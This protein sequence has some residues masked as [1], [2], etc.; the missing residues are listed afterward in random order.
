V[1]H[2]LTIHFVDKWIDIQLD[3]LKKNIKSPYRVYT[4]LGENYEEHKDKFYYC[5]SG[6]GFGGKGHAAG[7]QELRNQLR[8]EDVDKN[9]IILVLDS[10]A[11][12]IAPIDDYLENKLENYEFLAIS[13]PNHNF[14][15]TPIQP[16]E[17]FYAFRYEFFNKYDFW[18]K[19][20]PGVHANWIDWMID[21]FKDKKIEWYPL[22]RSNKVNLHPLYYAV[23]DKIIYHHWCGTRFPIISRPD[24]VMGQRKGI[25]IEKISQVNKKNS[26]KVINQIKNQSEQFLAYLMGEYDGEL[27]NDEN[28]NIN[29]INGKRLWE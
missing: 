18:F 27:E 6:K 12:P 2:I 28:K 7:L 11:F 29:K 5:V 20:K 19:F 3:F 4:K 15:K 21:W 1:I 26:E 10:D 14:R 8:H 17:C 16:F 24:R 23:Y 9:D 25:S 22:N 13:E